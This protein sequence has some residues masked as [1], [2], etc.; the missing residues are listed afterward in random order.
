MSNMLI[1]RTAGCATIGDWAKQQGVWYNYTSAARPGD[2]VLFDFSGGHSYRQHIGIVVSQTGNTLTT[3]EG[4]TSVT[5]NDNGGAVMTRTRTLSQV[6]GFIRPKYT[7]DQTAAKLLAIAKA[8]VGTKE[9]PANSN[10]CKYNTWYYGSAV[11]GSAYAWCVVFC[12]WCFYQLSIGKGASSTVTVTL[13]ML[14]YGSTGAEVKALQILL[15]GLGYSVGEADGEFGSK[16]SRAVSD[17]QSDK[18]LTADSVVG[19]ATWKAILCG[20]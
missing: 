2:L 16:T 4:N 12:A 13:P 8:E 15:N 6:V 3:I 10:K 11:S 20:S 17:F 9:Y 7:S 14:K 1:P 19:S 5:S 18:K